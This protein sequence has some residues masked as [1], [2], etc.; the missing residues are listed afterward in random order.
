ML[1]SPAT[2]TG[3]L[4][5]APDPAPATWPRG[6]RRSCRRRASRRSPIAAPAAPGVVQFASRAPPGQAAARTLT[7]PMTPGL[8]PAASSIDSSRKVVVVLP[9]VPV[10]AIKSSAPAPPKR[11]AAITPSARRALPTRTTTPG[12]GGAGPSITSARAPRAATSG[13]NWRASSLVPG[14][15]T[16]RSPGCTWRESSRTSDTSTS[17]APVGRPARSTSATPSRSAPRRNGPL[18]R[19]VRRRRGR[20][21]RAGPAPVPDAAG[22]RRRSRHRGSRRT[23]ARRRCDGRRGSPRRWSYRRNQAG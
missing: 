21:C 8:R 17:S 18:I 13:T 5:A 11:L 6:R 23:P 3:N 2:G 19:A 22:S 20:A 12:N 16:N 1:V 15:A 9:L 14:T 7:V 10:T 4:R